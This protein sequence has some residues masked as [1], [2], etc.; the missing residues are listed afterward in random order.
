MKNNLAVVFPDVENAM[1]DKV[2]R[3]WQDLPASFRPWGVW[4]RKCV[5]V[6][7]GEDRINALLMPQFVW[8]LDERGIQPRDIWEWRRFYVVQFEQRWCSKFWAKEPVSTFG[9]CQIGL[10]AFAPITDKESYYLE[11]IWDGKYGHGWEITP[12]IGGRLL[13]CNELWIA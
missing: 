11:T 9:A 3:E 12:N 5:A 2:V 13:T 7:P 4:I 1:L 10:A 6:S 8:F